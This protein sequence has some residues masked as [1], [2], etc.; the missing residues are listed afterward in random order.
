MKHVEEVIIAGKNDKEKEGGKYEW[1]ENRKNVLK[2]RKLD[3]EGGIV[4]K[5]EK[6][7]NG[8]LMG[9]INEKKERED[10]EAYKVNENIEEEDK[11]YNV[12]NKF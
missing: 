5:Y 12:K 8:I 9:G 3:V 1:E 11:N 6:Q 4:P 10:K 7:K 2:R